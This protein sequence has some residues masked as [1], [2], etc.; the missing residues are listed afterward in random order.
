MLIYRCEKSFVYQN[1]RDA[2]F[3]YRSRIERSESERRVEKIS[4]FIRTRIFVISREAHE[5]DIYHEVSY[6]LRLLIVRFSQRNSVD[7]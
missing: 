1:N 3:K 7:L 4:S 6:T 5:H 2:S